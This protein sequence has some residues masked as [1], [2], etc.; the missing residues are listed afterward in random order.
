M[1]QKILDNCCNAH[2]LL[3]A[4]KVLIFSIL[5]IIVVSEYAVDIYTKFN[6]K[7]TVFVSKTSEIKDFTLPVISFCTKNQFKP[8][9]LDKYGLNSWKD[10]IRGDNGNNMYKNNL[11]VWD[12]YMEASYLL[13]RDFEL[14]F[15][16]PWSPQNLSV[17][18]NFIK[19][20]DVIDANREE[21]K[22]SK[23]ISIEIKEYHTMASGTCYDLKS[24]LQIGPSKSV[25]MHLIINESLKYDDFP[26]VCFSQ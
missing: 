21:C 20:E 8:T 18:Q 22:V 14:Q 12:T 16:D 23:T 19:C 15:I 17:G 2:I 1:L 13:N 26:Q 25:G 11:S 4:T 5:L 10:F 6:D 3:K 7:A 9:V 24:N